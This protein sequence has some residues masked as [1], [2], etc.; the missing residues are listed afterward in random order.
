MLGQYLLVPLTANNLLNQFCVNSSALSPPIMSLLD[1]LRLD[2]LT[3]N[4]QGNRSAHDL[5]Y[6]GSSKD[7]VCLGGGQSDWL[8]AEVS[9]ANNV[10]R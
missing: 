6:S 1:H 4:K 10:L 2:L 9:P 7:F 5:G 8:R 3:H